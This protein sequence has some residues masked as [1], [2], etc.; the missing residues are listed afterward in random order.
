ML[1]ELLKIRFGCPVCGRILYPPIVRG[2][3]CPYCG[4]DLNHQ[5]PV[6][7]HMSE[8]RLTARAESGLPY[9]VG[10]FTHQERCY[11]Q[12]MSLSAIAEV[13]EKLAQYEDLEEEE[14]NGE[15]NG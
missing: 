9:Y 15:D 14:N 8:G 7:I 10:N 1:N 3:W 4:T 5:E 6:E 2:Y 13:L 12:D 11:A